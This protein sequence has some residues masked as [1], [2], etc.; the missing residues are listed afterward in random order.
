MVLAPETGVSVQCGDS[1]AELLGL[2]EE[3]FIVWEMV[4]I[5]LSA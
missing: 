5:L 1:V 4:V 2:S 3:H